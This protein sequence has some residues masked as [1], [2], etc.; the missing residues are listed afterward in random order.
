MLSPPCS[1]A[2]QM[3]CGSDRS[4]LPQIEEWKYVFNTGWVQPPCASKLHTR[5]AAIITSEWLHS[6]FTIAKTRTAPW[7]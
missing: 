4:G 5:H 6:P 7:A 3:V 2:V 1:F